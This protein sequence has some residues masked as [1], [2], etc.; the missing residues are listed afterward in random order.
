[1]RIRGSIVVLAALC[2][3]LLTGC[4]PAEG[5][6]RSLAHQDGASESAPCPADPEST[7]ESPTS[8]PAPSL[9]PTVAGEVRDALRAVRSLPGVEHADETTTNGTSAVPD[10]ACP[11]RLVT[12]NHF[13]SAFVVTTT[14]QA[15][16]EQAGAVPATMSE[17]LSW[18]GVDLTLTVPAGEGH[19]ATSVAYRGTF[20]QQI[21]EAT[22]TAVARGLATLAATPHVAG[23]N[24]EIPMTMRVDYGSLTIG[25]DSRDEGVLA[26]VRAVI[27]RTVFA[28]TTLHGSFGNGA[29]P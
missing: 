4:A 22:S 3:G 2:T 25:V 28:H 5:L 23:L 1:M 16:P 24:A 19:V 26:G 29:K 21:P 10:P 14:P 8:H 27:D 9:D 11:T 12:A 20:D 13:A 15:T 7:S 6:A 17:H 18:T